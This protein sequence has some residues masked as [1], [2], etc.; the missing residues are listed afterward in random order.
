MK[1]RI[2][3]LIVIGLLSVGS[4]FGAEKDKTTMLGK[5]IDKTI[6]PLKDVFTPSHRLEPIVITP[7]RYAESSLDVSKNVT[8]VGEEEIEKSYARYIPELLENQTGVV[9]RDWIGNGKTAN[10]D[11]R[12][13]GATAA[14]N[15]LVLI[16]GRRT[17]QIDMSGTDWA[18]INVDSIERIE[19]VR[20][21]QSV[22]YGDNAAGG[23]VNIITKSGAGKKPSAGFKYQ[24][25]SYRYNSY[26]GY[27]EGGNKFLDYYGNISQASTI[28][29][30]TNNGLETYDY[31]GKVTLKPTD[32]VKIG[33]EGGYHKDWYG[34]PGAL[35]PSDIN[36]VGWRGSVF[37][38]SKARTEDAFLMGT[39][40]FKSDI[41]FGELLISSDIL[42]R[43]RRTAALS[44]FRDG[45]SSEQNKRID[46][47]GITPKSAFTVDFLDIHNRMVAGIDYYYN[48]ESTSSTHFD[49]N[50]VLFVSTVNGED[51]MIIQKNNIGLYVTDTIDFLSKY[52]LNGGFRAEWAEYKFDQQSVVLGINK[53]RPHEYAWN[54]GANY[55]YNENSSLYANY[56][57]SFRFPQTD[58]WYSSLYKDDA[59]AVHGGLNLNLRTQTSDNYEIGIKDNSS[60]YLSVKADYFLIDTRHELFYN[61][62][63]FSNAV[64]DKTIR[65]GLELEGHTYLLNKLDC[66]ANYTYEKA[67]FVGSMFAGNTIPLVPHHKL[68]AGFNYTFM[69]CFSINYSANFVGARR[70]TGD[71]Q[72]FQPPMKA[73]F[74]NDVKLSYYKHGFK[75]Y[76]AMY[77]IF[78]ER[79]SEYGVLNSSRTIPAYYPSPG[80]NY[81]V[82]MEYKF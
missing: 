44:Y 75:V 38:N 61:P 9:V 49:W 57:R 33:V 82:G 6:S 68:S 40:E 39:P 11:V 71:Q 30:R 60:K 50:P 59:G 1:N 7:S 25:G 78:D 64:Y 63:I 23:V 31:N 37:P 36:S 10:V 41:G 34:Q 46:T 70:F 27:I 42:T 52:I 73:Y 35:F 55:R 29:Y 45:S 22:L 21:P 79:Y 66:F 48:K 54:V 24:T 4:A 2:M 26:D 65:H 43:G 77:N 5:T 81:V 69:D 14:L 28:G 53:K 12:G 17:N 74:T 20:G 67:F 19:I 18:Q 32:V 47:F 62:I 3:L 8:V 51:K 80:T 56:S 15:T 76:T 13:F 16:D 58:E 72:N